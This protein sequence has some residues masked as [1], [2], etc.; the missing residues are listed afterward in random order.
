MQCA[1]ET[2]I[3]TDKLVLI[4]GVLLIK[5]VLLEYIAD[6]L[7]HSYLQSFVDL[8]KVLHINTQEVIAPGESKDRSSN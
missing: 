1:E 5:K 3:C 2:S 4:I 8:P 7:L 6:N